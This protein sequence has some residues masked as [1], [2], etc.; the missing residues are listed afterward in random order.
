MKLTLHPNVQ[1]NKFEG[2]NDEPEY[3][4]YISYST[5]C[6]IAFVSLQREINPNEIKIIT[7][8]KLTRKQ[9]DNIKCIMK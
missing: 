6:Y 8:T 4:L 5:E 2:G 1:G 7:M 9:E 3:R